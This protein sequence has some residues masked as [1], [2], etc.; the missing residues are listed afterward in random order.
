MMD[1]DVIVIGAGPAGIFTA[2]EIQR[3]NSNMEVLLLEKGPGIEDRNCPRQSSPGGCSRC[4]PCQILSGWGG[5]GAYSDGKLTLTPRIGG[6]LNELFDERS[7]AG[8]I[9]YC[10][11]VYRKYGAPDVVYG[12]DPESVHA[13]RREA[14]A[15]GLDF[16]PAR[17]RHLGTENCAEILK[18]MYDDLKGRVTIKINTRVARLLVKDGHVRGVETDDGQ[19]YSA[20]YVVCAP[21]REGAAWFSE[22]AEK[23][24]LELT[25]NPVDIGVRVEVPAVV[26]EP[27]TD[28]VYESKLIYYSQSFDDKVRTFCVCPY[29]EVAMENNAGLT[30][31]N[32][33]SYR[34]RKTENTNFALLVSKTFTE[35]FNEPIRYGRNVASLANMLGDGVLV[36]RLGDLL[37]GRRSTPKRMGRGMVEPTL[38]EAV[39]GDISLALPYRHLT[40]ILEMLQA[41]DDLAPGV[42][43]RHTL[44][45]GIEVKFYSSRLNLDRNLETQVSGLFAAGDGAGIT[46]GL[47]QASASGVHVARCILKREGVFENTVSRFNVEEN[48]NPE[49]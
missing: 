46:R 47:A 37:A 19:I 45:Y 20:R 49:C 24:G 33:H 17:I 9:G 32:G 38:P 40:S 18:K 48:V 2:Y 6:W 43:S 21:G 39:P 13:L 8:L 30:T 31:V 4:Q 15:A 5:A 27:L 11:E 22:E 3:F 23:L 12:G 41:M 1:Y 34:N 36:Q 28:P 42:Y 10:D 35:P 16:V 26:M 29:G 25:R 14:A 44:L 7:V